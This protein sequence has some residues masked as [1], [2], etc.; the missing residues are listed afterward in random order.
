LGAGL[1]VAEVLRSAGARVDV[2]DVT[3]SED[4]AWR[5]LSTANRTLP[6]TVLDLQALDWRNGSAEE[7]IQNLQALCSFSARLTELAEGEVEIWTATRGAHEKFSP[8]PGQA[9][10]WGLDRGLIRAEH[11]ANWR[12]IVDLPIDLPEGWNSAL[13]EL[14]ESNPQANEFKWESGSW[15]HSCL[16]RC[17]APA[18][19]QP[20]WLRPDASYAVTG[21]FGALGRATA[22]YLVDRGA[23]HLVLFGRI[24]MPERRY[25]DQ[26]LEDHLRHRVEWV[27]SL[28]RRGIQVL[29]ADG[30]DAWMQQMEER[31]FPVLRGIV[32]AAGIC[33]DQPLLASEPAKRE[34]ILNAKILSIS[35]L[36]TSVPRSQLDFLLFY[37]SI[38]GLLPGYGQSVYAAANTYLDALASKLRAEGLPA[39][40]IAWGPWTVG[41]AG[42]EHLRRVFRK[43]GLQPITSAE[44]MRMLPACLAQRES[45]VYCFS[46][47][48]ESFIAANRRN[49]WQFHQLRDESLAAVVDAPSERRKQLA[50]MTSAER[51]EAA[52]EDLLQASVQILRL[53][54]DK[55][56]AETTLSRVGMDSLMAVELQLMLAE[57]WNKP[58]DI[59][60]ILGRES[61]G[62]LAS[63]LAQEIDASPSI[64][65]N[66]EK[67]PDADLVMIHVSADTTTTPDAEC[68]T[69][70][71]SP[72][73]RRIHV[74]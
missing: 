36:L 62:S 45:L 60:A 41:M 2:L 49:L 74:V 33:H 50:H 20:L 48:S 26:Q 43:Q 24:P 35:H 16:V 39:I 68:S 66:T 59:S 4:P 69:L 31:G 53:P 65:S 23:R 27:R 55:L 71:P 54:A 34:E 57:N 5:L 28:E 10:I 47:R 3:D 30:R 32:H 14:I 67:Q 11:S 7:D 21:G 46:M 29:S 38:A 42:D 72:T 6:L 13:R 22:D 15:Q 8:L 51:R 70:W 40:S 63:L 17:P 9:A 18:S 73:E 58:L 19:E 56:S 1:A 37:S 25:W 64:E 44:G 12:G 61:L 52:L